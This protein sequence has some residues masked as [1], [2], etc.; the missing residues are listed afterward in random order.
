MTHWKQ[1]M[2]GMSGLIRFPVSGSQRISWMEVHGLRAS[3]AFTLS[4][5][6]SLLNKVKNVVGIL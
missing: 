2:V 5:N 1:V 6:P 3:Q 4:H